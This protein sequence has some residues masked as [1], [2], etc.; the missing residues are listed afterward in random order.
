MI[1][2]SADAIRK[3]RVGTWAFL[4]RWRGGFSDGGGGGGGV[5]ALGDGRLVAGK[6]ANARSS[7]GQGHREEGGRS[8]SSALAVQESH[9]SGI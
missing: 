4:P 2:S 3:V 8:R 1:F 5:P 9:S 7:Q 6:G